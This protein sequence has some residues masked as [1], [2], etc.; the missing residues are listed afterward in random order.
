LPVEWGS[1]DNPYYEKAMMMRALE[2]TIYFASVNYTTR[3]P[4]SASS[5]ISP[6]GECL[7]HGT[8]GE[9]GVFVTDIDI[10]KAT[11]LLAKRFKSFLYS[12]GN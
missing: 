6:S 4:E 10:D 8:Y 2:N 3:F 9:I 5:L 1:P 7:A 11:G 12:K